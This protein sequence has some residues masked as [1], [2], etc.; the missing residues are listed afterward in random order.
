MTI[1]VFLFSI[2]KISY[3]IKPAKVEFLFNLAVSLRYSSVG[4][5]YYHLTDNRNRT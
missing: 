5:F 3:N 2:L 1:F 4:G